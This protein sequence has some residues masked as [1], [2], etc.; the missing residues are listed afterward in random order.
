M[1]T[2]KCVAAILVIVM[3]VSVTALTTAED[4]NKL[5]V[6]ADLGKQKIN[7]HIYGHFAEHLGRCIYG[8]IRMGED[9]P[10]P[11]TRGIRNDI[12]EALRKIKIPNLR[13]PGGCFADTY[14]W[15]DGIGPREKLPTNVNVHCCGVTKNNHFGTHELCD[16]LST[17]L[18]ICRNAGSCRVQELAQWVEYV[19][20]DGKSP[21]AE[22]MSLKSPVD[23][24]ATIANGPTY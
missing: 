18:L 10:I 15:M 23:R 17:E 13:W 14:H 2:T 4:V 6:N 9:S 22:L 11:N 7:K 5:I 21:I 8:G 24:I 3:L 20:F 16:Q 1:M 12:I 19:N